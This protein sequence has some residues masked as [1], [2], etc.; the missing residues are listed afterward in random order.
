MRYNDLYNSN[1]G[2]LL[3]LEIGKFSVMK[4]T[5]NYLTKDRWLSK[6]SRRVLTLMARRTYP[7]SNKKDQIEFK[8]DL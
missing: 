2:K 5:Q 4:T 3:D 7:K 1:I 6:A 8:Y